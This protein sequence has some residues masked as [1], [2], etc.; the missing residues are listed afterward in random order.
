MR[1]PTPFRRLARVAAALLLAGT[2]GCAV[3]EP[4]PREA[5]REKLA[6]ARA[7]WLRQRMVSYE[8]EHVASCS[9]FSL[10]TE[11]SIVVVDDGQV[12]E[13]RSVRDGEPTAI[14]PSYWP[15]VERLFAVLEAAYDQNAAIVYVNYHPTLGYPTDAFIDGSVNVADD[16]Y[17]FHAKGVMPRQYAAQPQ[18]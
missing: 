10:L 3:F 4:E 9:C 6:R 11:P 7:T 1:L 8:Y 5:E 12:T 18:R 2:G 15:T 14:S 16:E 13:V 17:S